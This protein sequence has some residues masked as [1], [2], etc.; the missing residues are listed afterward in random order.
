MEGREGED[1]RSTSGDYLTIFLSMTC[2]ST[3]C[4][5]F[6]GA[7]REGGKR[8]KG[9]PP[10]KEKDKNNF[11]VSWKTRTEGGWWE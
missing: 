7:W 5:I 8:N 6:T 10:S 11:L 3:K 1:H 9:P 4:L 2:N